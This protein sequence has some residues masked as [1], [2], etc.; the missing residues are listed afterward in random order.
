MNEYKPLTVSEVKE[1]LEAEGAKRE[2]NFE[3]KTAL[4]HAVMFT[5]LPADKARKL[6]GELAKIENISESMAV[7]IADLLPAHVDDVRIIFARER[8]TIN[9]KTIDEILKTV[10]KYL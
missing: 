2:L 6:A 5:K 8:F 7:K 9:P 4:Q 1:I 3:Q 10:E